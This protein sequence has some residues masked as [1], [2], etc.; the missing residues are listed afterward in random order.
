[1]ARPDMRREEVRVQPPQ[2]IR[3]RCA[4]LTAILTLTA[5]TYDSFGMIE[6]T[7]VEAAAARAR[8]SGFGAG[9]RM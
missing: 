8:T 6:L 2:C 4:R 5:Q 9:M 3:L 7:R 1:M